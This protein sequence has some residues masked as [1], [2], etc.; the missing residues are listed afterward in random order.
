MIDDT[1]CAIM[2]EC[3]QGEGGVVPMDNDYLKAVRKLCDDKDILMIIDEVQTGIG[4]T[5]KMFAFEDADII[6]DIMTLAKA[7]GGG[8][9]IGVCAVSE[10]CKDVL[11]AGDHGSTFGGNPVCCAGALAVFDEV[12]NEIF[13]NEVIKKAEYINTKLLEID[14][15]DFVRGKGLMIGIG[16]KN[17]IAKDVLLACAKNGLLVLTA[18]DLVRFLPPLNISYNE[19]DEGLET[20]EKVLKSLS[21]E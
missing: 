4:R 15:V 13:L 14:E 7:L 5:G 2:L 8:L 16:L 1:V 20:F 9:P 12:N 11:V 19:I 10:K 17:I 6:P 3:V 21:N 18:K